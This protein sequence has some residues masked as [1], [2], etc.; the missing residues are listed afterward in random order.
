[1]NNKEKLFEVILS[2]VD[3]LEKELV[4]VLGGMGDCSLDECIKNQGDCDV[5]KCSGNYTG[6]CDRNTCK[7]NGVS[8]PPG[9][10]WSAS[11]CKC[12]PVL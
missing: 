1:M 4:H 5:N 11:E 3:M 10:R 8:C 6:W 7:E 2:P 12:V 9:Y